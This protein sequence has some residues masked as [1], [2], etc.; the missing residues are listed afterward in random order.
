METGGRSQKERCPPHIHLLTLS[1]QTGEPAGEGLTLLL[2]SGSFSPPLPRTL[3]ITSLAPIPP[4]SKNHTLRKSGEVK[5][6]KR[7]GFLCVVP[8]CLNK[9]WQP[10]GAALRACMSTTPPQLCFCY[11]KI[12]ALIDIVRQLLNDRN[13]VLFIFSLFHMKPLRGFA[14]ITSICCR[15]FW[16]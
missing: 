11:R 12:Q 13:G 16:P 3:S 14:A 2:L 8:P 9:P 6:E 10:V 5:D 15:Y 7:A 4:C 1:F